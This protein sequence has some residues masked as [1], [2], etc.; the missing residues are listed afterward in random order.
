MFLDFLERFRTLCSAV[1]KKGNLDVTPTWSLRDPQGSEPRWVRA[2]LVPYKETP[3]YDFNMSVYTV[4][5]FS[6]PKSGVF[7]CLTKQRR[8]VVPGSLAK[9]RTS[10]RWTTDGKKLCKAFV[11]PQGTGKLPQ[12]PLKSTSGG[13]DEY[14]FGKG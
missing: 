7:L 1:E 5:M 13:V 6:S 10:T 14:K 9:C 3:T 4:E 8:E 12:M 11:F 2:G